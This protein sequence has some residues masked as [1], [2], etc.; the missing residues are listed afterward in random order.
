MELETEHKKKLL[1]IHADLKMNIAQAD[2]A[3]ELAQ[4]DLE[5][6][7]LAAAGMQRL[8]PASERRR[9]STVGLTME[10]KEARIFLRCVHRHRSPNLHPVPQTVR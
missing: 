4:L 5:E 8:S 2:M 1:K 7:E 3:L 6:E 10:G 9:R